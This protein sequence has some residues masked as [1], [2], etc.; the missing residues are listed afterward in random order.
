MDGK[1]TTKLTAWDPDIASSTSLSIFV[2]NPHHCD[3]N[4]PSIESMWQRAKKK[5]RNQCGTLYALFPSNLDEFVSR[6]VLQFFFPNF[7]LRIIEQHC[8]CNAQVSFHH[9]RTLFPINF[10]RISD[11]KM[12]VLQN[13][14]YNN[15]FLFIM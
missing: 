6:E 13:L 3:T 10:F 15:Y 2:V 11:R 9:I 5:L 7:H 4:K 14:H 1:S 12:K 8:N